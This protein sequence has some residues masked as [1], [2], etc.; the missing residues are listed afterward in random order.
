MGFVPNSR[1]GSTS[2]LEYNLPVH[3]T[4]HVGRNPFLS[5]LN[6]RI[7]C[8]ISCHIRDAGAGQAGITHLTSSIYI[9]AEEEIKPGFLKATFNTAG[10]VGTIVKF[11]SIWNQCWWRYIFV[12]L[13]MYFTLFGSAGVQFEQLIN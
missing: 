13:R 1:N 2:T 10:N 12:N 5:N 7:W 9:V 6:F 4:F 8:N 3:S 11:L